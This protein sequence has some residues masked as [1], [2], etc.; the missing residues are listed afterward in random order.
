MSRRRDSRPKSVG[1]LLGRA[2][3]DAVP[4]VRINA[5]RSLADYRDPA[6]AKHVLPLLADQFPNVQVEAAT[7]LGALGGAEAAAA[8]GRVV[9]GKGTFAVRRA[10]LVGLARA[11]TAAFG[12]A[13]GD[14]QKSPDWRLRAA[15][16]EGRAVAG[17]GPNPWFLA[18][19]DGRVVA[20]GLQ[21]WAAEVEG[22]DAAL[23]AAGRRLLGHADAG[24]RSV[25]GDVVSRA[26]DP[27]DLTALVAAYRRSARDSFP[28]AALAALNGI[29]AIRRSGAEAKSR[30]DAEFLG[31][32]ARPHDYI[33][34]RWAEDQWPEAAARWGPAYPIQTG[35]TPQDYRDVAARYILAADSIARPR[36]LID[37]E[38][39]GAVEVQLQGPEAPL[40]VANFVRLVERRFFDGHRWHRVVPNFVIQD[41]DPRGDGFGGPGRR[42]PGRDQS[43]AVRSA[44][45]GNGALRA[46]HRKQPVVHQPQPAAPPRRDLH[47]LRQG[48]GRPRGPGPDHPGRADPD[49]SHELTAAAVVRAAAR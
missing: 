11:D 16:A 3:G 41:G 43:A 29:L 40:T 28:D 24:V 21:A 42:H 27:A 47:G 18:D 39:R 15:A 26:G 38:Q 25:A 10:A 5:V 4:Q 30:V 31:A 45:A 9:A 17:P 13:A 46:R 23:L 32:V 37:I 49:D 14:W 7:T 20:T 48:G 44:D 1:E 22:P 34:R 33:L 35:R 8:L 2:A 19:R 12:R 36:V 6:L